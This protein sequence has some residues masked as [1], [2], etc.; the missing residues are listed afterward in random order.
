MNSLT[1]IIIV[2]L[3]PGAIGAIIFEKI[4]VSKKWNSF[5]FI[6]NSVLISLL[7]YLALQG[8]LN[9]LNICNFET[10]ELKIWDFLNMNSIP[11]EEV[12]YATLIGI[13]LGFIISLAENRLYLYRFAKLIRFSDLTS[14][15]NIFSF[16]LKDEI[17]FIHFRDLENDL[18]YSGRLQFYKETDEFKELVLEDVSVY[19]NTTQD[20]LYKLDKIY[21]CRP[22]DSFIFEVPINEVN[23]E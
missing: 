20:E 16:F 9:L 7:S 3:L 15:E 6:L 14:D 8:I 4:T 1:I 21:I 12:F 22:K 19:R 13:V 18:V 23:N 10:R 2:L 5:K 17:K 11:Y